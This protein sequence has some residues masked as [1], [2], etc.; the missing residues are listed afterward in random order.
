MA[1]IYYKIIIP[2]SGQLQKKDDDV[3]EDNYINIIQH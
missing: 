1:F 2:P 3:E